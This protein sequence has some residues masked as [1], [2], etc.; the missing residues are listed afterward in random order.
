MVSYVGLKDRGL[1]HDSG[2]L[3]KLC[4]LEF[5]I[6]ISTMFD[7]F[8]KGFFQMILCWESKFYMR[9]LLSCTLLTSQMNCHSSANSALHCHSKLHVFSWWCR[10]YI[11]V[12]ILQR[13]ILSIWIFSV[14]TEWTFWDLLTCL[15]YTAWIAPIAF[16][17]L[18]NL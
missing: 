18:L 8:L 17:R 9:N 2:S 11:N 4:G 10:K 15:L 5:Q 12:F 7:W 13:L 14:R 6:K 16:I 1:H 3:C